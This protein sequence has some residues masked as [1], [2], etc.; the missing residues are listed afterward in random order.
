MNYLYSVLGAFLFFTL[1][2]LL[3]EYRDHKQ[4]ARKRAE[5]LKRPCVPSP[6][7]SANCGLIYPPFR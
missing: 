5:Y 6:Q 4:R 2:C 7:R 3:A 1:I